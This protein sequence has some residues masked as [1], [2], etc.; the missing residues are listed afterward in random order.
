MTPPI[1]LP[2]QETD[3]VGNLSKEPITSFMQ[4]KK[5]K[6]SSNCLKPQHKFSLS[7]L[8]GTKSWKSICLPLPKNLTGI[9]QFNDQIKR[10][11]ASTTQASYL[12]GLKWRKTLS[13]FFLVLALARV[14]L[15]RLIIQTC[16][17]SSLV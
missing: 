5:M 4:S 9:Y 17:H 13:N 1:S 6:G 16:A 3:H 10:Q 8:Y 14:L 11:I 2:I 15:T 7:N 12:D